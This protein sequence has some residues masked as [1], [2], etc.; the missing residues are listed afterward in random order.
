VDEMSRKGRVAGSEDGPD[1]LDT[2]LDKV[3]VPGGVLTH[4]S[5]R[6]VNSLWARPRMTSDHPC[7]GNAATSQGR[8]KM[9]R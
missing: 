5:A 8:D 1:V 7:A 4:G 6:R 2:S 3:G 9:Q